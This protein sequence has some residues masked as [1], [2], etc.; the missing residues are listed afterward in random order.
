MRESMARIIPLSEI[1][2]ENGRQYRELSSM[3]DTLHSATTE[4]K[5]VADVC[6]VDFG[7]VYGMPQR[8]CEL[9]CLKRERLSR[10]SFVKISQNY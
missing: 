7:V 9:G 4:W 8:Q 10:K 2:A 1:R 3:A 6:R 5:M